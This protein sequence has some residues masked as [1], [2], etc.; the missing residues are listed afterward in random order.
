MAA[1]VDLEKCN[2]EQRS[3]VDVCVGLLDVN[4]AGAEMMFIDSPAGGGKTFLLN[5]C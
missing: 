5:I 3:I 4:T 2:E 1:Q